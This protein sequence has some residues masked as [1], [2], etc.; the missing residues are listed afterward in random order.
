MIAIA[1]KSRKQS[2]PRWHKQFLAML[3]LIRRHAAVSF[4]HLDPEARAE[5][6]QEVV[7]NALVAFRRLVELG[8]ADVAFPSPLARYGVAQ[9]R[10]GRRT[11]GRLNVCDV[12]SSYCQQQKGVSVDR[13]D[14]FDTVKECWVE[15][16]VEDRT[17][18][19]A[20]TAASRIDFGAWLGTLPGKQRRIAAVLATGETTQATAR[21]FRL[22]AGR[23]SQLR[24]E[25]HEAWLSFVGEAPATS[26]A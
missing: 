7:A 3:P 26:C 20:Q 5:A 22:T 16:L 18:G 13:L 6:V 8:K 25:L 21:K 10:A 14:H 17:A 11:G 1:P 19:P 9:V 4:R 2:V 15:V 12:S 23:I 24:R